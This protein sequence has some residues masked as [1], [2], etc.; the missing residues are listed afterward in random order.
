MGFLY[1]NVRINRVDNA[2][3][4]CENFVKFSPVT[5]ELTELIRK[6]QTRHG[7]KTGAF[8]RISPD[9]LDRF[10]NLFTI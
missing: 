4:S 3:I 7:Q 9:I 5:S 2:S 10:L 6:R 1:L 8:N